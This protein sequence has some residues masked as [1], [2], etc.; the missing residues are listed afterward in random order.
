MEKQNRRHFVKF[1]ITAGTSAGLGIPLLSAPRPS[2]KT[3]EQNDDNTKIDT[4][5]QGIDY[6]EIGYCGYRCD[7]C[8][9]RSEDKTLRRKMVNGWKKLYGHTMYT[10]DNIPIAEPCSGCKGQGE[11]ADKIC[12]ARGC[13]SERN[14]VLCTDCDDFP[15]VKV[16][17]LLSDRNRLLLNC[18]D[19]NVSREEYV[20]S[21]IQFESMPLLV[22][23]MVDTGRLP[24]WMR[25]LL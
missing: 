12:K 8:V 6:S 14:V 25:E 16:R 13:A 24:S 21:A 23:R 7:Q 1:C 3:K 18:K 9:G 5:N 2:Q 19:K 10:E 15:C 11:V 17:P 22:R 4:F 20:L